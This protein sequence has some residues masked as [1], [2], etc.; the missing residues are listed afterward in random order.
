[1]K[2]IVYVEG[3]SDQ[4]AL[5]ALLKPI[6]NDGR[7]KRIGISFAHRGGKDRIF[8]EVPRI[9]ADHLKQKVVV[10]VW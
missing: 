10:S 1:L 9:A 8:D 3:P 7:S 6:I 5:Q 2:V 4:K